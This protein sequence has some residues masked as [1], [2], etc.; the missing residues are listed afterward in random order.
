MNRSEADLQKLHNFCKSAKRN[1]KEN[2]ETTKNYCNNMP[3]T[4]L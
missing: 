4:L 1:E 2:Y 3:F